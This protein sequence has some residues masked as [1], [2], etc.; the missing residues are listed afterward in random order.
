MKWFLLVSSLCYQTPLVPLCATARVSVD[1]VDA[2][3]RA[4]QAV[5]EPRAVPPPPPGA[6]GHLQHAKGAV[7]L[8]PDEDDDDEVGLYKF[9]SV[10]THSLKSVV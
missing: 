1:N 3:L 10:V 6:P 7:E 8:P 5:A 2:E 9:K 4:A